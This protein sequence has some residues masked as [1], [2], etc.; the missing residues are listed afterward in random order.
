MESRPEGIVAIDGG[1]CTNWTQTDAN[2]AIQSVEVFH[3][4]ILSQ[5]ISILE[6]PFQHF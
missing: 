1:R 2:V 4:I 5:P 6:N 3:V